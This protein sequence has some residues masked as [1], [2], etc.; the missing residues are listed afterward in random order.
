M[1]PARE[2]PLSSP[3]AA[4]L[5]AWFCWKGN[6]AASSLVWLERG[7]QARMDVRAATLPSLEQTGTVRRPPSQIPRKEAY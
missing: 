7:A 1:R 5:P 6:L 3:P 2:T 4:Q